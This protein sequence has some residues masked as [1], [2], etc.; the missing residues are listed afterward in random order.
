M[1]FCKAHSNLSE[2]KG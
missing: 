1:K 2:D